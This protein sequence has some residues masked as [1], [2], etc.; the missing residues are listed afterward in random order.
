MDREGKICPQVQLIYQWKAG[1]FSGGE[2]FWGVTSDVS[3]DI[4]RSVWILIK[5][6]IT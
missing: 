1:V 6:L 3:W 4:R 5:I 2:K